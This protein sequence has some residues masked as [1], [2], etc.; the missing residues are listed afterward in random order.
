MALIAIAATTISYSVFSANS[1][2]DVIVH[3]ELDQ[4]TGSLFNLVIE[5]IGNGAAKNVRFKPESPLPQ[6]AFGMPGDAQMPKE[7]DY[8]P[9]INGI[10]YMAPGTSRKILLGQYGG[11]VQWLKD[12]SLIINV[13]CERANKIFGIPNMVRN[14]SSIDVHSFLGTG[15]GDN[16]NAKGIKD[17]LKKLNKEVSQLRLLIQKQNEK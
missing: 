8:G 16:S 10:P 11:L 9:I 13:E 15:L 6:K 17:E 14:T 1:S 4:D 2:P 3:L 5:N 7:M 12:E